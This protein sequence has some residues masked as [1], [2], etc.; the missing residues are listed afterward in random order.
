MSDHPKSMSCS[1]IYKYYIYGQPP[2]VHST[3]LSTVSD[4][5]SITVFPLLT[6]GFGNKGL[7]RS[8][9]ATTKHSHLLFSPYPNKRNILCTQALD[10]KNEE[11][12]GEMVNLVD[13]L[14]N[15]SGYAHHIYACLHGVLCD[16][17]QS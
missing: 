4:R 5:F 7:I 9:I 1:L 12:D 3:R 16:V 11:D 14:K 15:I 13:Y 8:K 6:D 17:L 2:C 10:R